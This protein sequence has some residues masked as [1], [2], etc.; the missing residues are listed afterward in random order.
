MRNWKDIVKCTHINKIKN[1]TITTT[2]TNTLPT[3][4]M[5]ACAV[6]QVVGITGLNPFCTTD[7]A[8]CESDR[9]YVAQGECLYQLHKDGS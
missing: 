1:A 4:M 5:L 2:N 9:L 8:T 7:S 3:R 6:V